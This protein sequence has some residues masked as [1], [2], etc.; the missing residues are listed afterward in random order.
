MLVCVPL[1]LRCLPIGIPIVPSGRGQGAPIGAP[2]Q[3]PISRAPIGARPIASASWKE[4]PTI[5]GLLKER[6]IT[7]DRLKVAPDAKK[8]AAIAAL[9]DVE[10]KLKDRKNA[11][12]SKKPIPIIHAPTAIAVVKGEEGKPKGSA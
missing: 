5:V 1:G 6:Q 7:V 4:D 3:R 10:V 8:D 12:S 2:Q 9:R 11:L